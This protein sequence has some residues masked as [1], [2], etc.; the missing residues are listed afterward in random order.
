VFIDRGKILV[1]GGDGGHGIVSFRREKHI[2]KGGPDGGDGGPG[3][4]VVLV[5]DTQLSTLA[6]LRHR[7]HFHAEKGTSGGPNNRTGKKGVDR[8]IRVPPGTTVYD[9]QGRVIADLVEPE[10]REVVA[11]GGRGGRGNAR[12]S[13]NRHRAPAFREMGEPGQEQWIELELKLL[14]D[15]G[16]VGNP[17]A[18]KSTLLSVVSSARPQVAD[19]PFTTLEPNLGVV[20]LDYERSFVIADLPGLIQGAHQGVGLGTEFLRH[21]ERTTVILHLVD[22]ADPAGKDPADA[23]LEIE[24]ELRAYGHGL[25]SRPRIV[26]GTKMDLPEAQEAWER[27]SRWLLEQGY[28]GHSISA[29]TQQGVDPLME[30]TYR[31]LVDAREEAAANDSTPTGYRIY[32]AED[33]DEMSI[34]WN[35][36]EQVWEVQSARYERWVAMTDFASREGLMHLNARLRRSGLYERL[37]EHG[38]DE[39]DTVR[40]GE[41]EFEY[42]ESQHDR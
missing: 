39:G 12:F 28:R 25:V 33:A 40:I 22:L 30:E 3:G 18:G 5:V 29:A 9:D 17:N 24:E 2:P 35:D 42:E 11:R 27:F 7:R 15:V 23:F 21:A 14:A 20:A 16:L 34:E 10:Q 8:Q 37:R 26:V 32:R 41:A 19:Y 38:V 31:L 13:S 4:D 6:E 36:R 1:R